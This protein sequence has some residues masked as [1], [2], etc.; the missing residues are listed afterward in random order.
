ML[1]RK[2]AAEAM[3]VC[4][5]GKRVWQTPPSLVDPACHFKGFGRVLPLHGQP[6]VHSVG[7]PRSFL[8]SIEVRAM[9]KRSKV[10]RRAALKGLAAAGI[11]VPF[12][13]RAHADAAPSETLQHASF[14][15]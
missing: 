3:G 15:A 2:G 6:R 14:G 7:Q 11:S 8:F 5:L 9:K 12:V 4:Q 10:T 13:F 1:V